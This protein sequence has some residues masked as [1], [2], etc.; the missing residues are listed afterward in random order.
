MEG[1]KRVTSPDDLFIQKAAGF[2]PSTV[3]SQILSKTRFQRSGRTD[4]N[5]TL[6]E[7][8]IAFANS[9]AHSHTRSHGNV[10]RTDFRALLASGARLGLGGDMEKRRA[11]CP[12]QNESGGT[13]VFAER[14]L[15]V[16][17]QCQRNSCRIV[18]SNTSS[19]GP[20]A[21]AMY[22]SVGSAGLGV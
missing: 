6:T 2:R 16:Q 22:L 1:G 8:A 14:A 5:A 4:H 15:V 12:A 13:K 17:S 20:K 9:Y 21:V 18:N 7:D 11:A 19:Y 3:G 10:H